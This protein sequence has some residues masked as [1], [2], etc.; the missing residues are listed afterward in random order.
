MAKLTTVLVLITIP[1]AA[2]AVESPSYRYDRKLGKCVN[3]GGLPGFNS[4]FT[5]E[6]GELW[7]TDLKNAKLEKANL[8]GANLPRADLTGAD[9]TGADLTGANLI[10]ARLREAKLQGAIFNERTI[11]PFDR[12]EAERL[13]M[14]FVPTRQPAKT[15][16]KK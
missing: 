3:A 8:S 9:L 10:M 12:K 4:K 7:G 16:T 6:C 1:G 15:L 5:G 14:I 11:L 13:G 2:V